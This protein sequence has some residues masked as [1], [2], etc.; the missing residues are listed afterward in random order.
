MGSSIF[1][2]NLRY[3]SSLGRYNTERRPVIRQYFAN[4]ISDSEFTHEKLDVTEI[5]EF[6]GQKQ[7]RADGANP[8]FEE[9]FR[10]SLLTLPEDINPQDFQGYLLFRYS[11]LEEPLSDQHEFAI[12]DLLSFEALLR[13]TILE[14]PEPILSDLNRFEW[15]C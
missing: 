14:E 7:P 13:D 2:E 3:V 10:E 4:R 11:H 15:L 8:Y 6:A 5:K 1:R 9:M 12:S